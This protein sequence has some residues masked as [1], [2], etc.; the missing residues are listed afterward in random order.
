M[1][2]VM[3]GFDVGRLRAQWIFGMRAT[4]AEGTWKGLCERCLSSSCDPEMLVGMLS[5]RVR[6]EERLR[7]ALL[8]RMKNRRR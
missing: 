5:V 3:V 4:A 2:I 8:T 7:D 1:A 6:V